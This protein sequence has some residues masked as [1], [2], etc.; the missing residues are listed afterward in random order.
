MLDWAPP[1]SGQAHISY[2]P[3]H[4][5]KEVDTTAGWL[6]LSSELRERR[7]QAS[8]PHLATPD[9]LG[10]LGLQGPHALGLHGERHER[11]RKGVRPRSDLNHFPV[12]V[13]VARAALYA[14][15]T[16]SSSSVN[17]PIAALDLEHHGQSCRLQGCTF[18]ETGTWHVYPPPAGSVADCLP[19]NS[20]LV[21]P[22]TSLFSLLEAWSAQPTLTLS[23]AA[24]WR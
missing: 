5:L 14:C 3:L 6:H 8:G 24:R 19:C 11:D 17:S 10:V 16:T 23:G 4:Q 13:H 18:C 1:W 12:L 7:G 15:T 20:V 22:S 21:S 2:C 9:V